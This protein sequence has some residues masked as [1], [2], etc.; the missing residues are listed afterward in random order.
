MNLSKVVG[1]FLGEQKSVNDQVN[2]KI[3]IV[4]SSLNKKK[5]DMHSEISKKYDNLQ[6]SISKLSNQQH[7]PEKGK[8]PSQTQQNPR[9]MHEIGSASYPNIRIDEVKAVVT[10]RSGT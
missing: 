7:G 1:D 6:S 8:F 10:V 4:E 3:E 9:G 5:D 2:K